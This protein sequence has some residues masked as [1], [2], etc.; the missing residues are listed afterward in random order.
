MSSIAA[1][2]PIERLY[3]QEPRLRWL[4]LYAFTTPFTL[5]AYVWSDSI[6]RARLNNIQQF[7]TVTALWVL[8]AIPGALLIESLGRERLLSMS[9]L[10]VVLATPFVLSAHNEA[11]IVIG[12]LLLACSST[13]QFLGLSTTLLDLLESR[14]TANR[15]VQVFGGMM[16]VDVFLTYFVAWPTAHSLQRNGLENALFIS[17]I[18]AGM[19]A[20][21]FALRLSRFRTNSR[22]AYRTREATR[23][24]LSSRPLILVLAGVSLVGECRYFSCVVLHLGDFYWS[25]LSHAQRAGTFLGSIVALILGYLFSFT[26]KSGPL[27]LMRR[28]I[29]AFLL[30][31]GATAGRLGSGPGIGLFIAGFFAVGAI[32]PILFEALLIS[33]PRASR[34]ALLAFSVIIGKVFMDGFH[35]L[36]VDGKL[37]DRVFAFAIASAT[38]SAV[39]F[40]LA[41][42]RQQFAEP[43]SEAVG[44]ASQVL[45]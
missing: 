2:A 44:V 36:P 8:L 14:G 22:V 30:I 42:T 12:H 13:G 6:D 29:I 33:V 31:G 27:F 37:T 19:L 7:W 9:A 39:G 4:W 38:L 15:F 35:Q 24:L 23:A 20:I 41:R 5:A 28:L 34:L 17:T 32:A 40:M 43:T 26:L 16:S 10:L 18:V 3:V 21:V 11:E 45:S 25:E 1:A